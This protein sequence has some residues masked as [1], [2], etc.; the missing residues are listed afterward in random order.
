MIFR[1]KTK[2]MILETYPKENKIE[3][4]YPDASYSF[5]L[6]AKCR[7]DAYVFPITEKFLIKKL[8]Q[9]LNGLSE[10]KGYDDKD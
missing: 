9:F 5:K 8:E 6:V 1:N 3:I 10:N 7:P 2:H 4:R